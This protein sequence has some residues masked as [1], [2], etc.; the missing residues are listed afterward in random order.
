[1]YFL[2]HTS[3]RLYKYYIEHTLSPV[4]WIGFMDWMGLTGY[5]WLTSSGSCTSKIV[6]NQLAYDKSP[7]NYHTSAGVNLWS[8]C[9]LDIRQL[10]G[11]YPNSNWILGI[12]YNSS[13]YYQPVMIAHSWFSV[14]Y[15]HPTRRLDFGDFLTTIVELHPGNQPWQW[16]IYY[17]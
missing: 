3:N 9:S 16:K 12:S 2:G 4:L 15:Y 14:G 13:C 17:W 11:S 6:V 1:M 8:A 10:S 7:R 5:N